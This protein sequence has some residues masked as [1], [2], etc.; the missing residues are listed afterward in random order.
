[1]GNTPLR[2]TN[3]PTLLLVAAGLL[4]FSRPALSQ[5]TQDT[6]STSTQSAQSNAYDQNAQSNRY[7][8]D[9][10]DARDNDGPSRG[11]VQF[12]RFMDSHPDVAA[13]VRKNPTLLVNYNFVQSHPDL[14]TFLEDHPQLRTE[15]GQNPVAFMQ[16]ENS[17]DR[18]NGARDADEFNHFLDSHREIAEQVHKNPS[19]V[20]DRQFVKN[21]EVLQQ[22]LQQNPGIRDELNRNPNAFAQQQEQAENREYADNRNTNVRDN[23]DATRNH[24]ADTRDR[25]A[26]APDRDDHRDND[27]RDVAQFDR[28]L[29]SHREIAEQLRKNPSLADNRE[30]VQNHPALQDYLRDNPAIRDEIAENP[31]A[32]MHHEDRFD[33]DQ[34]EGDREATHEHMASFGEFL[35][36]HRDIREDV[37]RHPS[38]V[39]DREYVQNHPELDGYL[40]SHPDVRDDMMADPDTFI[41]GAQ[42]FKVG[43]GTGVGTSTS[44]SGSGMSTGTSTGPSTHGSDTTGVSTGTPTPSPKPKQ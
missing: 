40:N 37:T 30:F 36:S 6:Q 33:Q 43:S 28:F 41:K 14:N 23:D 10:R 16:E 13:Q 11:V 42:Q 34:H 17:V 20:N 44:G 15:I 5:S 2:F 19:L 29:D 8:A 18:P 35:G 21:H 38:V 32:F 1:M 26:A 7:D 31:N 22:F 24:D 3:V 25:D 12:D 9:D 39:K 27:R 4:C